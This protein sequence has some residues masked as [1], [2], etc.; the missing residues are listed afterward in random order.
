VAW[1]H[2]TA[3]PPI[4]S[5]FDAKAT[6]SDPGELALGFTEMPFDV[7]NLRLENAPAQAHV[8]I[9]WLRSVA[10]IYHAFAISSFADELAHAAGAD[11]RDYLLSLVG[12]PRK[13][14]LEAEGAKYG[15]YG[16]SL[17]DYP[18]DTG[19]LRHVIEVATK[20]TGWGK[21]LPKGRGLG[22]AAHRSFLTYVAIV[23]EVSVDAQGTAHVEEAHVAFDCGTYVNPD[24]VVTQAQGAFVFAMSGALHGKITA[25]NGA[26][27]QSN[28]HDYPLVR[29][30]EAPKD[31]HV[32]IVE[33]TAPPAG[34]GEPGVPPVAPAIANAIFAATG[35]RRRELPLG[36]RAT[37]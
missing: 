7:P 6:Y 24:T 10:N 28:F 36:K 16:A 17:A 33:S 34:V 29:I 37:A 15:N 3:F 31:I 18:V 8:R 13:I 14:D 32:H 27:E 12:A 11:P 20:E 21:K 30:N 2:R 35:E 25:K 4:G 23:A 19:R 5:T 9:G 26:I 22:L 1:L